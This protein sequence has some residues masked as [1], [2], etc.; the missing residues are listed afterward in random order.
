M[1]EI[2]KDKQKIAIADNGDHCSWLCGFHNGRPHSSIPVRH[3]CLLS[4]P[5]IPK[6]I[7]PVPGEPFLARRSD[8]CKN[9]FGNGEQE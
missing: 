5:W 1:K 6:E 2:A 7:E 3:F 4:S 8:L 9:T